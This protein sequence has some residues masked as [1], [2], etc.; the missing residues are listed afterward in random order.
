MRTNQITHAYIQG[1]NLLLDD[2]HKRLYRQYKERLDGS[3]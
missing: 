2:H 3:Q 1:R